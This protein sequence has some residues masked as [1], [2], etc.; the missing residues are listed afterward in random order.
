MISN[1]PNISTSQ[2]LGFIMYSGGSLFPMITILVYL[3]MS[4]LA[5][6]L[7]RQMRIEVQDTVSNLSISTTKEMKFYLK[8]WKERYVLLSQLIDW[9]NQCFGFI[10][11]QSILYFYIS[12]INGTFYLTLSISSQNQHYIVSTFYIVQIIKQMGYLVIISF[13]PSKI[14]KEVR[15]VGSYFYRFVFH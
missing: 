5:I 9:I 14:K 4:V 1:D 6:E 7:Y 12:V 11:L 10:L 15:N 2:T 3:I 8:R 13:T